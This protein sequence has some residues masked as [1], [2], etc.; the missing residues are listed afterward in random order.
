[1]STDISIL[2]S[3]VS[4]YSSTQTSRA[5]PCLPLGKVS[6][7]PK[8]SFVQTIGRACLS[9][10]FTLLQ[11][12]P[13]NI[14]LFEAP[15]LK[16][17]ASTFFRHGQQHALVKENNL[18]ALRDV[19]LTQ[20][21]I[22][23][24]AITSFFRKD[25]IVLA[26]CTPTTFRYKTRSHFFIQ[27][28]TI[29]GLTRLPETKGSKQLQEQ[30]VSLFQP[31]IKSLSALPINFETLQALVVF[32]TTFMVFPWARKIS[33]AVLK[34]SL[35]IAQVLGV[36]F[37]NPRLPGWLRLE[38]K[39]TY[40]SLLFLDIFSNLVSIPSSSYPM[41]FKSRLISN[42]IE[43]LLSG[44]VQAEPTLQHMDLC[45]LIFNSFLQDLNYLVFLVF[46]I[47]CELS[48]ESSAK[49]S[50]VL[51]FKMLQA[52]IGIISSRALKDMSKLC[53]LPGLID[54]SLALS[55]CRSIKLYSYFLRY[56]LWS[57][58][59]YSLNATKPTNVQHIMA[60]ICEAVNVL[61]V[62][63]QIPPPRVTFIDIAFAS[64]CLIFLI[65]YKKY[66][67]NPQELE[68]LVQT[69]AWL[70]EL[71]QHPSTHFYSSSNMCIIQ[72]IQQN[73]IFE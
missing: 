36:Q 18:H 25:G 19:Y 30:L 58:N 33:Y 72:H 46:E 9:N 5:S 24:L 60:T 7:R 14:F 8:A 4:S 6:W 17:I 50:K 59:F 28:I 23:N 2:D 12:P 62:I 27:A 71:L 15:S 57:L 51:D 69:K 61:G 13:K 65:R 31:R 16:A 64:Q 55:L 45:Y 10:I 56:F 32:L 54:F 21:H 35:R 68:L 47:K 67:T 29:A 39:L 26:V 20:E 38:R 52:K 11:F 42:K 41:F 73:F 70:N 22:F 37:P 53:Y 49:L 3:D 44:T 63:V 40:N 43:A 66:I 48:G 1:M 34:H